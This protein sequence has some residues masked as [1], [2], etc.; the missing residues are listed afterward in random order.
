MTIELSEALKSF[1]IYGD[2]AEFELSSPETGLAI[3]CGNS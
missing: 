3:N 2:R 1:G